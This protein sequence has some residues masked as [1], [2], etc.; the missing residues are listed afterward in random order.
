MAIDQSGLNNRI[1]SGSVLI[2]IKDNHPL[3][4]LSNSLN[5]NELAEIVLPD[6]KKTTKKGKWWL[7]RSLRL[8]IHLGAFLLQQ[9]HNLKDRQAEYSIK[10]NA[11][12]KLFCGFGSVKKWHAP[13]HT[14]IEEFRSR[15]S[16]ETQ[17]TLANEITRQA[18][19]LGFADPAH[20]DI[21]STVQEA[22]MHYP[23][24]SSLLCKLGYMAKRVAD[25]M[26][27]K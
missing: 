27:E 8:R 22:N 1:T 26:N 25:Y 15:L 21:D 7:G 3:I 19:L 24:D 12:Y 18:A 13:D 14:K 9:L 17:K 20:I 5:W 10:D 4:R 11:A 16:V 2:E 6:L 23:T